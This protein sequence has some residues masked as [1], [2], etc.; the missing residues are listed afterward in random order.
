MAS[1]FM[2]IV[3]DN[4]KPL[5][6]VLG[7][8]I[9][10][11]IIGISLNYGGAWTLSDTLGG[12]GLNGIVTDN[13]LNG[14]TMILKSGVDYQATIQTNLGD[15][16][17][18]L[19]ETATPIA[20]NNFVTL[21]Q[22]GFYNGVIFHRVIKGFVIQGGDPQGDGRGGPGYKFKDEIND[23]TFEPYL[24][25]MANSG[26]NTNGSQF[27]I[28]S[29]TFHDQASLNGKYTIFGKVTSGFSVVD[30]IENVAVDNNDKPIS[31]VTIKTIKI[32]EN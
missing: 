6:S 10:A 21:S 14:P 13:N 8:M 27:F 11:I 32:I 29:K 20:V 7:V 5:L 18:D 28:T 23:M 26:P 12:N 30:A 15:I 31:P 2:D 3:K 1:S 16:T 19:Y 9:M 22:K 25:A 4:K 24:L 17:V